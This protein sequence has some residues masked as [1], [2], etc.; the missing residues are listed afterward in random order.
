M[1]NSVYI[2]DDDEV[3]LY[4]TSMVFELYAPHMQCICF[5]NAIQALE[6]LQN[7]M[8]TDTVP[9]LILLDLNM[10]VMSGFGFLDAVKTLPLED[11]GAV[12]VLTSSVSEQDKQQVY[13]TGQV[14]DLI[15]KPFSMEKL[16]MV[17]EL[18][19]RK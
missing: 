3:S 15:Q 12:F 19:A 7:S 10:P 13:E 2:I 1:Q 5:D 9:D 18:I 6:S 8:I 14:V 17:L 4:L 16:E 11:K